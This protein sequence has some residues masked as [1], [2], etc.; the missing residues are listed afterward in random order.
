MDLGLEWKVVVSKIQV[1]VCCA[2]SRFKEGIMSRLGLSPGLSFFKRKTSVGFD[3]ETIGG[4]RRIRTEDFVKFLVDDLKIRPMDIKSVQIHPVAPYCFVGFEDEEKMQAVFD[5]ISSGVMWNGKGEVYPFL[6]TETYTEVK[7]KGVLP[8]TDLGVVANILSEYGQILSIKEFVCKTRGIGGR[9]GASSGEYLARMKIQSPIPRLYCQPEDGDVWVIY[10]E[11]QE[12]S[13]WKCFDTGHTTRDCIHSS[14]AEFQERQREGKRQFSLDNENDGDYFEDD[15]IEDIAAGAGNES[16]NDPPQMPVPRIQRISDI[17]VALS[18]PVAPVIQVNSN[19]IGDDQVSDQDDL[20]SNNPALSQDMFGNSQSQVPAFNPSAGNT[21]YLNEVMDQMEENEERQRTAANE[22]E[23]VERPKTA[24]DKKAAKKER[25][26]SKRLNSSNSAPASPKRNKMGTLIAVPLGEMRER[27][28]SLGSASEGTS[29][30]A[31]QT[32]A[33]IAARNRTGPPKMITPAE[34]L[35][36][37][38]QNKNK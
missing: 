14:I 19:E 36:I 26:R 34:R 18:E 11:G 6:C 21:G 1:Q 2:I 22:K 29:D 38:Y 30:H 20:A 3:V 23:T 16:S 31:G 24:A 4:T 15:E 37:M 25:Q 12:D 33:A 5:P 17:P 27:Q 9:D 10:H 13:C 32:T 28:R 35:R 7:V 8:G